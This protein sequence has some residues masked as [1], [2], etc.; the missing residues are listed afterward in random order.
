MNRILV[1]AIFSIAAA[2]SALAADLPQPPPPQAPVAY[3]P[4]VAPVYNW[5]GIYVGINGGWGFGK[6]NWNAGVAGTFTGLGGSTNDNGGVVGGTIGANFQ[7]DA[8]VLGV[9]GDWDYSGINTGTTATICSNFGTCQTGNNWLSTVRARVGWAAD[10]ILFYGTGG[11]AFANIQTTYSGVQTTKTQ[12]GWTVGAGVEWAFADNWTARVEY[13]YV[14]LGSSSTSCSTLACTGVSGSGGPAI[15][16]S[17]GLT[18][19]LVRAG[20]DFKFR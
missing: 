10:R 13:L 14:D 4:T 11:G 12:T 8:F 17:A 2:S 3:I 5:G 20:V 6:A 19:S 7:W 9:E 16:V 18:E 1:T 15:P